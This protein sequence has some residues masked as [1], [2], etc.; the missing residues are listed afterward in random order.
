MGEAAEGGS[1]TSPRTE[2]E[3]TVFGGTLLELR[4]VPV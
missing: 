3:A 2:S 1:F 4:F